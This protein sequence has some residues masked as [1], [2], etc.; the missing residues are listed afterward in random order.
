V[1][2]GLEDNIWYDQERTRRATNAELVER[3]VQLAAML[4]RRPA[5]P[6]EVRC[7]LGIQ[8]LWQCRP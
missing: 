3:V 2:V 6:R 8:P 4:E 7:R 5:E 1:R